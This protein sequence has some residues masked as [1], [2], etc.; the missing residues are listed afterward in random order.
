MEEAGKEWVCPKCR[1]AEKAYSASR[2][3]RLSCF[4][5]FSTTSLTEIVNM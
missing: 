4:N 2:Q 3:V 1:K 5:I